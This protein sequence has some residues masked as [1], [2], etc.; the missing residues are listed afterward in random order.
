MAMFVFP[1]RMLRV[2]RVAAVLACATA[3]L[4]QA[5]PENTSLD[6]VGF[7]KEEMAQGFSNRKV[8]AMP[9]LDGGAD[10]DNAAETALLNAELADGFIV[11]QTFFQ[12]GGM[13]VILVPDGLTPT[14]ACTQLAATGRYEFVQHDHL[15]QT[16][17]TP[18]DPRFTDE[19]QWHLRNNGQAGGTIGADINAVA[20]WDLR[21]SAANVIVA[22]IDSGARLTHQD[23]APN[24]W[25]NPREIAGNGRDD[26]GNG[27]IDDV[28]GINARISLRTAGGGNPTDEDV[29]RSHG[30]HVAGI[31]GAV[32]NN[33][34]GGSGVAWNVQLMILKFLGGDEGTGATSDGIECIDYAIA[35]GAKIINASY[36]A[37]GSNSF[38]Q[39][40][41]QAIERAR[42]A[43]IIF[44]AASGNDSLNLDISRAYPASHLVDNVLAVGNSTRL[45]DLA[46]SS[47]TGSGAVDLFA[48]GSEISSVGS[49]DDTSSLVLSGTSMAAPMVSGAVALLKAQFPQ[50]N[51]RQTINRLLRGVAP[52]PAFVGKARTGGRLDVSAA[53]RVTDTR[54]FN[55]DFADRARLVGSVITVRSSSREATSQAGEPAHAGRLNRS[56][57]FSWT[58]ATGGPVAIDTRGSDGDT[59][60]AVYTGSALGS[61][62][63]V[64]DNDNGGDGFLSSRLSFN[65]TTGT[66]YQIAVDGT[67][68]G[69]VVVNLASSAANDAFAS[70]Q[71]LIGDAPLVTTTN[72]NATLEFRESRVVTGAAGR[73]LWYMWQALKDGRVQVS[74]YSASADPVLGVY[75]GNA[76]DNL[77]RIGVNDDAGINGANLGSVVDFA[78]TKDTVYYIVLDTMD[79]LG[80]ETTLSL[81]D[82]LWQFATG[83]IS[84]NDLRRPTITNA[85][86]VG[87]DGTVY[88][89]S[90]DRFFYAINP[91][92][93]LRW[94]TA[95]DF[96]SDSSAAAIAPDGTIHFGTVT[97]F[98]YALN[99]DGT[100]RWSA[101]PGVS[102]FV[103]APAVAADGTVYF[104][105]DEGI[106]RAFSPQGVERWRYAIA[107]EGS[108]AGPAIGPDSTIYVSAN[109]GAIH[110]LNP[111]G[112]LRW[113]F[114]PQTATG[115]N[116][117]S[118]IYTS[119]ALDQDGNLYA[120]TLNGTTFSITP[121]GN[122]RWVF[123]TPGAGENVSSSIAL[124]DGRAYFASYAGLLYAL[125]QTDGSVV[126]TAS[127]EAQARSSSPAIAADG[128]IIVGSYANKLF[129]FSRDGE[130]LR[131]WAAG[132][133]FRSSPVLANGRIY[134]GNGDGKVYA[135]NLDGVEPA[136]G[137]DYPWPQYRHG[138]RHLGR[139]S[140]E[141]IGR[142]VATDA[143]NPGR[144]V[145]LSVRNRTSRGLDV[146]TAGFVLAGSVSKPLVIRGVG[147]ALAGFGVAESLA[148]SELQVFAT[149]NPATPVAANQSWTTV[150]GDGRELGAFALTDNSDDSV[151]RREFDAQPFTAQV[152]PR[153]GSDP[154]VALVEIYDA[155]ITDLRSRLTNLSARTGLPADSNVT[156]GFV[157]AGATPRTVLVRAIGP[158]LA[159]FGVA[160]T[161]A[162]P[163][164]ILNR[165]TTPES[166]NDDWNGTAA[167]RAA[168]QQ[169][170]AFALES[171]SKDAALVTTLP[172]GSY[173]VQVTAPPGQGGIVLVEV[174]LLAE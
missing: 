140:V 7:S 27:Y 153:E 35:R 103:A 144:L 43:G 101:N 105:Q 31:I 4:M 86:A 85:P 107:G 73:T 138:P 135:F 55:D 50:D 121:D 128:S 24:L 62:T 5:A 146:L 168:A 53:L 134:V 21:S 133:W 10:H 111:D 129:R 38:D 82:A 76:L 174:Y 160:D 22:V 136:A 112:S 98:V 71:P 78:A 96:Y 72:A 124:G 88:V 130:L 83:D 113:I 139:A 110:A 114:R 97:G 149:S 34:I 84:D 166:G 173:T 13:R 165:E 42:A 67:T 106:T 46:T 51:Y 91:D 8:I 75:T 118:G 39:A 9:R 163:K 170:G 115:T 158:G 30:T 14:E 156:V 74:A 167:V 159:A 171:N 147:P 47:N 117:A 142:T 92:G 28:H 23:L 151:V 15:L 108:Y 40:Q 154:G 49:T 102:G 20:A 145:N 143:T 32:G 69:L 48:P 95:T 87:P 152:L 58:A 33:G 61:L 63:R 169:V 104:K 36:G 79:T 37:I 161:V 80:G 155:A 120:C 164:I 141:V 65:A 11:E 137:P 162:D 89:S 2:S 93:S 119:P 54:P 126:W 6:S 25:I 41:A 1:V 17:A 44:V 123:R 127:I 90:T 77:T 56:L 66:T 148:A 16:A 18:N 109:D 132:N 100:V 172:P 131:A 94:R 68:A 64:A 70:A 60:L 29:T 150:S 157:I 125:D 3:G 26:D 19:T 81:T 45:D 52:R 116:D 59:Q 12:L 57:W 99:P 122:L